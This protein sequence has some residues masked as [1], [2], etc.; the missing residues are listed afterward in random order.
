MYKSITGIVH[1]IDK[2]YTYN[3]AI[4]EVYLKSHPLLFWK[5]KKFRF[6]P[7]DVKFKIG[8]KIIVMYD[9]MGMGDIPVASKILETFVERKS[10]HDKV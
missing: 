3:H 4:V 8:D 6:M 7:E 1:K 10:E 2:R 9:E 5:N